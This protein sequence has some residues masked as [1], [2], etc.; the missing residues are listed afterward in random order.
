VV[1]DLGWLIKM[2]RPT[3][4]DRFSTRFSTVQYLMTHSLLLNFCINSIRGRGWYGP[5]RWIGALG[6]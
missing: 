5:Q 2:R 4:L 1:H 6:K 3:I